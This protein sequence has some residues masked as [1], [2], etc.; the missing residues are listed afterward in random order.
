MDNDQ[1]KQNISK[2]E[3]VFHKHSR[4]LPIEMAG[5]EY[6]K[7]IATYK[8]HKSTVNRTSNK[9]PVLERPKSAHYLETETPVA[10]A[11]YSQSDILRSFRSKS[12]YQSASFEQQTS[13]MPSYSSED[14]RYP[15]K[16]DAQ[17]GKILNPPSKNDS[18]NELRQA[19][20]RYHQELMKNYPKF[21]HS[22][23]GMEHAQKFQRK[24]S[25]PTED[26][27]SRGEPLRATIATATTTR[28]PRSYSANDSLEMHDLHDVL[29]KSDV[30]S[31]TGDNSMMS[32]L[33]RDQNSATL[34]KIEE[35]T[36][37]GRT[38]SSATILQSGRSFSEDRG[39]TTP[40]VSGKNTRN[41]IYMYSN[42]P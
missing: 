25:M 41:E 27:F 15:I 26:T 14:L 34:M 30:L 21:R 36:T 6:E 37:R 38:L 17:R 16:D 13:S 23:K 29:T 3:Q 40:P 33:L 39:S 7:A 28:M 42:R 5:K 22:I 4:S 19:A 20:S 35:E 9:E 32:R 24:A 1:P 10:P 11:R 12:G 31:K 8:Q 18:A 2:P